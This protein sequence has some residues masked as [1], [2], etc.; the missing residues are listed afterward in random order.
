MFEKKI[1]RKIINIGGSRLIALPPDFA[2]WA[3]YVVISTQEDSLLV[4][5]LKN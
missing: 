2:K 3:E 5:P 1:V 4:K